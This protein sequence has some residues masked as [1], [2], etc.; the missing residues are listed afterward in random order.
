MSK[1]TKLK[2]QLFRKRGYMCE[3]CRVSRATD[4]D[5]AVYPRSVGKTIN[6]PENLLL[7]CKRCHAN[8]PPG[9]RRTAWEK[10]VE[11]YGLEHMRE[12]NN[13]LDLRNKLPW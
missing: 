12:W 13:S 1:Y 10:N 7:L 6:D 9:F 4:V 11:R 3:H 5:H 2:K 8:K